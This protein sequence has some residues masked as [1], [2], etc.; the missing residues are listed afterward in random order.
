MKNDIITLAALLG[1]TIAVAA[2]LLSAQSPVSVE[3]LVGYGSVL[4]LLG[5]AALEYRINWRGLVGR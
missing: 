3:E 5:V 2:Y 4:S 1:T